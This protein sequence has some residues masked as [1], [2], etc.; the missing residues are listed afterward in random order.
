MSWLKPLIDSG[1]TPLDIV[2]VGGALLLALILVIV[3]F[4]AGAQQSKQRLKRVTQLAQKAD[5]A[6]GRSAVNV[7]RATADSSIAAIDYMIKR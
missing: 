6:A 7:K 2:I 4:A 5:A 1:M 3:A